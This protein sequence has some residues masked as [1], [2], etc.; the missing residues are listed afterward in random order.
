MGICPEAS[1]DQHGVDDQGEH[2]ICEGQGDDE[3]LHGTELSFA[4]HEN[5]N[6]QQV[7]NAAHNNYKTIFF[8]RLAALLNL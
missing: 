2:D 1:C 8:A 6:D 5:Q 7:E 4:E 3:H